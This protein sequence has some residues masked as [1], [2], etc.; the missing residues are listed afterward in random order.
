VIRDGNVLNLTKDPAL[1]K[2]DIVT[3]RGD[4]YDLILTDGQLIGSESDD[5]RARNVPLEV[6]D[7]HVGTHE[8]AGKSIAD[9]DHVM[10]GGVTLQALF[11]GGTEL[12][13]GPKSDVHFGDVLRLTG[14]DAALARRQRDSVGTSSCPR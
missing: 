9:L 1:R 2:G 8:H 6:A 5:P 14:P 12:P 13:L 10:A 4:I 7:V 3:V 11:R